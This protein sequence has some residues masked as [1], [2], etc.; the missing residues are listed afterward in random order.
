MSPI[1][2]NRTWQQVLNTFQLADETK[3]RDL[4]E[5]IKS[6]D[7]SN[8]LING[9]INSIKGDTLLINGYLSNLSPTYSDIVAWLAPVKFNNRKRYAWMIGKISPVLVDIR[10]RFE[11]ASIKVC[12]DPILM[13]KHEPTPV[14]FIEPIAVSN[15]A[16]F[17]F[18]KN[19]NTF[20]QPDDFA[21]FQ[22]GYKNPAQKIN[23]FEQKLVLNANALESNLKKSITIA[24]KF[25]S[26]LRELD[27][28]T[29]IDS[30]AKFLAMLH[31]E[32]HNRGHFAGSWPFNDDKCCLLHEATEE[33]R[34]CLNA[35]KWSEYLNL[36]DDMINIF[37]FTVFAVR[38]FYFG[39][40]AYI[41]PVKTSQSIREISV[42]L[43]FFE[44][45]HQE[46]VLQVDTD[47]IF[48]CSLNLSQVQKTLVKAIKILNQQEFEAKSQGLEGLRQVGRYWY[49]FAYPNANISLAAEKIYSNIN[50][51]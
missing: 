12:E 43:M 20:N 7:L 30:Q 19:T 44:V 11:Q 41:N 24:S 48:N 1:A 29:T 47:N 6:L 38:F 16:R 9:I 51:T 33:F 32:A 36:N 23:D 39:Y 50:L 17:K 34:A 31:S 14:M 22:V 25:I 35:I 2:L 26:E 40:R 8:E 45:L 46:N 37:A 15:F 49:K 10:S 3:E 42:G 18:D 13:C 4:I 27:L 5:K 21:I 28:S